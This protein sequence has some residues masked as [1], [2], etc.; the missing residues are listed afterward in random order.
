MFTMHWLF[1]FIIAIGVVAGKR[2]LNKQ[3]EEEAGEAIENDFNL[4]K[5][6]LLKNIFALVEDSAATEEKQLGL[7]QDSSRQGLKKGKNA[8]SEIVEGMAQNRGMGNMGNAATMI[9][10]KGSMDRMFNMRDMTTSMMAISTFLA[11][12]AKT[13]KCL[14]FVVAFS[15]C[16][17]R[18]IISVHLDK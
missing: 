3:I 15:S 14:T 11:V 2:Q 5:R 6:A 9:G 4:N 8:V 10:N 7:G 13:N 17:G 18:N 1:Y 16:C 12:L